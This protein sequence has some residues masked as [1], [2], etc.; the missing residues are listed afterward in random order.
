MATFNWRRIPKRFAVYALALLAV[1]LL[2]FWNG[3]RPGTVSL[4]G[5]PE[6]MGRQYGTACNW[7]IPLLC[8]VYLK[9]VLCGNNAQVL[10]Q[11]RQRAL[12]LAPHVDGRI[13]RELRATGQAAR[14]DEGLLLLGNSFID[15]G[16]YG[17]AC[18]SLVWNR[19][20]ADGGLLHGHNLDWDNLAGLA[21]WTVTILRRVPTDGRYRTVA[22]AMPGVLGALDIINDHGVALSLNQVGFGRPETAAEPGFLMLRRVAENCATYAAARTELLKVS[23]HL[24]FLITLSSAREG[25]AGVF[26]PFDGGMRE[27]TWA[28][29]RLCATNDIWGRNDVQDTVATTVRQAELRTLA[30]VR[31]LLAAD[32]VLLACNIY[33]VVFDFTG[34]RLYLA[35]GRMPAAKRPA[36]E[37]TLF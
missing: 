2:P 9:R 12:A 29:D 26:E 6:E 5:S 27:R 13:L 21:D 23:P 1:A 10:A 28:G 8:R 37:F 15:L 22:I 33:S 16:C 18:R 34:N 35:S 32:G 17:G 7:S 3:P 31:R 25:R 30:D 4:R 36:R 11:Q 14:V 24:P 20:A 19:P